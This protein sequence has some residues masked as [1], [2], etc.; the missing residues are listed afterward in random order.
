MFNILSNDIL[1]NLF[2]NNYFVFL[3]I[4][5]KNVYFKNQMKLQSDSHKIYTSGNAATHICFPIMS[6]FLQICGVYVSI[7]KS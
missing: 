3:C 1:H 6:L 4:F 2:F 5:K 7:L